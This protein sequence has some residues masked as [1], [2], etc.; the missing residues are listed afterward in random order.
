MKQQ[1]IERVKKISITLFQSPSF[2]VDMKI[3]STSRKY[4]KGMKLKEAKKKSQRNASREMR[5]D[6]FYSFFALLSMSV[7]VCTKEHK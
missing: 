3:Y 2:R 4:K 7:C 6:R 1:K 5:L